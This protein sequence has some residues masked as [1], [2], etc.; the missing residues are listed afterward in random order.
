MLD[1]L[2]AKDRSWETDHP[3]G[4]RLLSFSLSGRWRA[5]GRKGT[6]ADRLWAASAGG[7]RVPPRSVESPP[8][9]SSSG[10]RPTRVEAAVSGANRPLFA[11]MARSGYKS[12]NGWHSDGPEV[13]SVSIDQWRQYR[14]TGIVY[15]KRLSTQ[16]KAVF[17]C[18]AREGRNTD[19]GGNALD[20]ESP[21]CCVRNDNNNGS[22]KTSNVRVLENR[23]SEIE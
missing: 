22:P 5:A 12:G 20:S 10:A 23:P 15:G 13:R 8:P 18:H 9:F 3:Q 1:H 16:R 4:V 19:C 14:S 7:L 11:W 17:F 6:P 2:P 21:L